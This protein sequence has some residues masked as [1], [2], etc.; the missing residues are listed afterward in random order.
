MFSEIAA[1]IPNKKKKYFNDFTQL[2]LKV[3][4]YF[5]CIV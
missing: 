2:N 1:T 3:L 4:T 5:L